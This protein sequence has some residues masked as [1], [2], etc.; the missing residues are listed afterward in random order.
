MPLSLCPACRLPYCTEC[1]ESLLRSPEI[2]PICLGLACT[3]GN[4]ARPW[5]AVEGENGGARFDS[6][7]AAYLSIGPGARVLKVWKTAPSSKLEHHL[8]AGV[9]ERLSSF[10]PNEALT[11][12]PIPQSA[13]RRW[14]LAGGSVLRLCEMIRAIRRN[15]HDQIAHL[16]E[17]GEAESSQARSRGGDRYSRRSPI[18]AQTRPLDEETRLTLTRSSRI[19]LVDDFLTSGSTLRSAAVA[20]R[21]KIRTLDGRNTRVDVFVLG[22]RPTLFKDGESRSERVE[23]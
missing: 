14:E 2:C 13:K 20:V 18:R 22:F 1:L 5:T 10:F 8:R 9:R 6:V 16:L 3:S 7:S 4:C 15:P 17:V 19:V 12:V 21:E 23:I 11:F